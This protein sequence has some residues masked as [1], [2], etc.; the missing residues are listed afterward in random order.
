MVARILLLVH[1][2]VLLHDLFLQLVVVDTLGFG[3]LGQQLGK[4]GSLLEAMQ[5]PLGCNKTV[6]NPLTTKSLDFCQ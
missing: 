5:F 6:Q 3:Q 2:P 1:E 4:D